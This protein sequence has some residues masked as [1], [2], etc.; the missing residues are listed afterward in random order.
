ML[1]VGYWW[2]GDFYKGGTIGAGPDYNNPGNNKL[3]DE[4]M[5]INKL[6]LTF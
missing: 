6:T 3:S 4:Y 1:G 5:V 2:V